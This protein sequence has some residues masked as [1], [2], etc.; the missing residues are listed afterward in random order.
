MAIVLINENMAEVAFCAVLFFF[1]FWLLHMFIDGKTCSV[2]KVP[3]P[4]SSLR[5]FKK[6]KLQKNKLFGN[7]YAYDAIIGLNNEF[8]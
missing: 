3:F 8:K 1:S 4:V 5:P 7:F 6:H 2:S